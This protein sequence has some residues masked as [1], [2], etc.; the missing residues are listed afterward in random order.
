[1]EAIQSLLAN[2]NSLRLEVYSSHLTVYNT[3]TCDEDNFSNEDEVIKYLKS[4]IWAEN[5]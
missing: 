1:M 3:E 5:N 4:L 2:F